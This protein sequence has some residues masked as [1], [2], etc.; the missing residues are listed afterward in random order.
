MLFSWTGDNGQEMSMAAS[1]LNIFYRER[2]KKRPA[3]RN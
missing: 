1:V 2:R 3:S